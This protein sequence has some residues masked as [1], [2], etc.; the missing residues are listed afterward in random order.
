M[1]P[2]RYHHRQSTCLAIQILSTLKTGWCTRRLWEVLAFQEE[3]CHKDK[4]VGIVGVPHLSTEA[5]QHMTAN[6]D[7]IWGRERMFL[8]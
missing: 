1:I 2:L 5:E 3:L 7:S 8:A 6:M 4:H